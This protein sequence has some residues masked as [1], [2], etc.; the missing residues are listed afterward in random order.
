M[1]NPNGSLL[2]QQLQ[3]QGNSLAGLTFSTDD[4]QQIMLGNIGSVLPSRNSIAS[5]MGNPDGMLSIGGNSNAI[6]DGS[7][8]SDHGLKLNL[9]GSGNGYQNV[10]PQSSQSSSLNT[11][12]L[13]HAMFQ[14]HNFQQ[15]QKQLKELQQQQQ[16]IMAA[17]QS[18]RSSQRNGSSNRGSSSSSSRHDH[19][20]SSSSFNLPDLF[21]APID[22]DIFSELQPIP[23]KQ[24]KRKEPEPAVIAA[25]VVS[26]PPPQPLATSL[27]H[28]AC[29]L[30]PTTAAVV[31]SALG[32]EKSNVRRRVITPAPAP[33][34]RELAEN[35]STSNKRQKRQEGFSLPLHIAIDKSGSME[36]F[37]TLV[38]AGPD[39]VA[40]PDGPEAC[41]AIALAMYK[42]CKYEVIELLVRANPEALDVLDRHNNTCLHVAC[43]QGASIDVVKLLVAS[44]DGAL[45][46]KN[47][48]GQTPLDVAQR[49]T[50]C[51]LEVIDYLQQLM[52]DVLE[53]SAS[54][55][56]DSQDE[57][58]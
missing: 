34:A 51:P 7:S 28:Q 31:N 1:N 46:K 4:Y 33:P 9:P 22:D 43:G 16:Q 40:M 25:P 17:A 53:N 35:S 13:Q 18:N 14:Q 37:R 42:K 21:A 5:F 30:Y 41:S 58:H 6:F 29:Y 56:V 52:M 3:Q 48:H 54:H 36:V 27:L 50:V 11:H 24:T 23:L 15:Q 20:S 19:C 49:I 26:A 55:L 12:S 32:V 8:S 2:Q 47:F 57:E 38:E 39:V 44:D 45:N 10:A